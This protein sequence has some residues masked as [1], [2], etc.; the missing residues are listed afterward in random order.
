MGERL[1]YAPSLGLVILVSVLIN[2]HVTVRGPAAP[3]PTGAHLSVARLWGPQSRHPFLIYFCLTLLLFWYSYVI[4]DRNRNWAT[5]L[6][7]LKS[8]YEASPNSVVSITNM[9]IIEFGNGNY[10]K[11]GKWAEKA[12]AIEPNHV[13]ALFLVGH[14]YKNLGNAKSA[15]SSWLK[16][17][18]VSPNYVVAYLSLGTLYYEQGQFNKAEL[19]F[20]KGFE[21]EKTWGKAFPLILVKINL[22]KYDEAIQLITGNFGLD[23]QKKEIK[24]TLGLVY[25]KKGDNEKAEFYLSQVKDSDVSVKDYIKKVR[26]QK[27]FKINEY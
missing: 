25:L 15:E 23:L 19:A 18:E 1:M 20:K 10:V 13:P 7:L 27:T 22:G 8:G 4:I 5:E 17:V 12:L 21:L 24:F 2:K 16:L 26:D 9:G 3:H 6:A 11:A 14:A